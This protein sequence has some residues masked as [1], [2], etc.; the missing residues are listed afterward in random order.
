MRCVDV[1]VTDEHVHVV[2]DGADGAGVDE[3]GVVIE[4]Q[5]AIAGTV[6]QHRDAVGHR[7]ELRGIRQEGGGGIGQHQVGVAVH[8]EQCIVVDVV[9]VVGQVAEDHLGRPAGIRSPARYNS[10]PSSCTLPKVSAAAWASCRRPARATT[11]VLLPLLTPPSLL[12]TSVPVPVLVNVTGAAAF[13][14]S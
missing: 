2:V 7:D 4:V 5:T 11:V 10:P 8:P 14:S 3:I 6:G 9:A 12:T 13:E 1:E